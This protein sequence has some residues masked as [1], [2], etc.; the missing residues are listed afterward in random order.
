VTLASLANGQRRFSGAGLVAAES[1]ACG[2]CTGTMTGLIG[3]PD[4]SEAGVTYVVNSYF[5][6]ITGVA[7]FRREGGLGRITG[8]PVGGPVQGAYTTGNQ[9]SAGT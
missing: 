6:P 9:I 8:A 3:G 1:L 2:G 5:G 4:A 7:A